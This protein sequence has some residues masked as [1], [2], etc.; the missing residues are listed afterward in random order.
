M[1][2]K[3]IEGFPYYL[4]VSSLHEIATRDDRVCVL[5]ILGGESRQVTP[6][7]HAFS[8]GNVVFGTSPGRRGQLLSTPIGDIPVYNNVREGLDDGLTFNTGVVYL[9]PSGVRDGVAELIRV[10]PDLKKIVMI[11]EKVAVHDA[12]EIRA[13]GQANGIDIFRRQL[14]GS[15]RFLEP[16]A[17]RGRAGR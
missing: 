11:T 15:R 9:P 1:F 8:G 12:R 16:G 6:V 5:N 7:S 10:N 4:G 17:D 2:R 3:G 13:L 14:F